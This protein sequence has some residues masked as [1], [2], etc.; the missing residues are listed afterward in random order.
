MSKGYGE[1]ADFFTRD[2]TVTHARLEIYCKAPRAGEV[3]KAIMHTAHTGLAGEGLVAV[4]PV[5]KIYRIRTR[6]QGNDN[7]V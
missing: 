1:Y 5:E 6:T 2:W 4:F 7:D 3:A